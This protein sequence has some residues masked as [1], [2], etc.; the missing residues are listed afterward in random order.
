MI[1]FGLCCQFHEQPIKFRTTTAT[2]LSKFSQKE[3]LLKINDLCLS[4]AKAL[5]ESITYCALNHIGCFRI[6]SRI[7]PLKTHPEHGYKIQDLKDSSEIL[8]VFNNCFTFAK[9]NNIRLCFHPDQFVV[10]NSQKENVVQN[11]IKELEYQA[12]VAEL[13][14]ADVINIHG[15]GSYGDKK[16]ALLSFESNFYRLSSRVRSRLTVENDDTTYTPS[17][18]LGLCE[19]LAIPL[20]YDA[21]HHR[22]CQDSLS[23]EEAT[24]LSKQTWNREP[25]FHISSPANGWNGKNPEKHHDYIDKN[26]FPLI[27]KD[28][29]VTV[30]IEAK[31]KECAIKNLREELF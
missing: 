14:G 10:L 19:N 7:L 21:H 29:N 13:V 31:A 3:N 2:F 22:C 28:L 9:A 20:V 24:N 18:L 4:N 26:D 12:E 8:S 27:W 11:S 25:L 23:V 17:D 6:G 1:R 15:G 16:A 5:F 30:E